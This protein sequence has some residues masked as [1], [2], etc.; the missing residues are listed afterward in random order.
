MQNELLANLKKIA[1]GLVIDRAQVQ[2]LEQRGQRLVTSLFDVMKDDPERLIPR[3][4]WADRDHKA[5]MMRVVCD[6]VAG[7]TD[8][9]AE[10]VYRRLF[11]PGFGSS[12]DEL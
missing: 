8:A 9:Y 7:M 4:S 10:K 11:V 6:Y 12:G 1:F 2:Q 3:A 5:P